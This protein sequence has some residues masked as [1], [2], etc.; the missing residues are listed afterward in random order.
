MS[1]TKNALTL[2][3]PS[4]TEVLMERHFNAPR[5][6]VYECFTK[7]ER[8]AKWWGVGGGQTLSHCE[9]DLRVGGKWKRITRAP[10]GQETPFEG[11]YKEIVPDEILSYTMVMG[12]GEYQQPAVIETI[13]L[14]DQSGGTK[15]STIVKFPNQQMRDGTAP[16]MEP[17]AGA[18]YDMLEELLNS[19][20]R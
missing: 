10:N 6:L 12:A 17:G 8:L 19:L 3:M 1:T 7:C 14:E 5:T 11:E 20:A 2:T 9:M 4:D 16:Y 15:V 18:A 13:K